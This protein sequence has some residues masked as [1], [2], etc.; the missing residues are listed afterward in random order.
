MRLAL[1]LLHTPIAVLRR[2]G[3]VD[4]QDLNPRF[5]GLLLDER[6]KLAKREAVYLVVRLAA[7]V[8]VLPDAAEVSEHDQC[9]PLTSSRP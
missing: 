7:L 3:F 2:V 4:R 8:D 9:V 1:A 6:L 5:V